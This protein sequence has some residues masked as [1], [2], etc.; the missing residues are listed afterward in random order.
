[1]P[2]RALSTATAVAA[3]ALLATVL[4]GCTATASPDPESD[5][6]ALTASFADVGYGF[7]VTAEVTGLDAPRGIAITPEDDLMYF[8]GGNGDASGVAR[9][10]D[11]GDTV[12][13]LTTDIQ[14]PGLLATDTD[15]VL[16]VVDRRDGT[17]YRSADAAASW[18]QVPA[19]AANLS[20]PLGIDAH[21]GVVAVTNSGDDSV[22]V[23]TDAGTSW[24]SVPAEQGGFSGVAGV[25]IDTTS[26]I[27]VVNE[28]DA[29]LAVSR[30]G[31]AT[32]SKIDPETTGLSRPYGIAVG[33]HDE[34][35][36]TDPGQGA[37]ARSLD[38]GKTWFSGFGF[39]E[40]T[41]IALDPDGNVFVT[42]GV[43]AIAQLSP[44]PGPPV[45]VAATWIDD[46]T[47]EV[48]WRPH[49][50]T[51]AGLTGSSVNAVPELT[52]TEWDARY[53][54]L[55][56]YRAAIEAD[57]TATPSPAGSLPPADGWNVAVD[58]D[59]ASARIADLPAG[60][61]VRLAVT[62]SNGAG[63]SDATV[64]DLPAR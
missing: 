15:G 33:A 48:S 40:P 16:Y 19:D 5:G 20:Q 56:E 52:D 24:I 7:T 55:A 6:L 10:S 11:G 58:G 17:I 53:P 4:A 27:W 38:G 57:P 26:G 8:S 31:G 32:W 13:W 47:V 60:A 21:A 2:R 29:S 62:T 50:A 3:G 59:T 43:E 44:L 22:S 23:S 49:P 1:M 41:A 9:V 46:T 30:D 54:G 63:V 34:V 28:A 51:G 36:V 42:D 12:E 37:V 39:L 18:T 35:Y 45:D 61:A 25:A 64:I 14:D